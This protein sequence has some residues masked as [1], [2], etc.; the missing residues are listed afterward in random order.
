[1]LVVWRRPGEGFLVGENIEVKVIESRPGKVKL[2]II[3]PAAL[4]IVRKEARITRE[5]NVR[6]AT[7][8]D[9]AALAGLLQRFPTVQKNTRMA[10]ASRDMDQ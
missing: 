2:G 3:A 4:Q 6:A 5:E 7:S 1:M 8:V 10:N 9:S